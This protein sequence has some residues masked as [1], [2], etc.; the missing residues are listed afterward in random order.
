MVTLCDLVVL[1]VVG[2]VT[3]AGNGR[4]RVRV[5]VAVCCFVVYAR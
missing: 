2:C 4:V 5:V 1:V 3:G